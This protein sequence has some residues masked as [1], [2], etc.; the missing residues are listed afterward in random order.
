M[1]RMS[2]GEVR[3]SCARCG[4]SVGRIDGEPIELPETWT[5]PDGQS[6]CLSCSRARAGEAAIDLAPD[7][8]SI[9]DRARVRRTALIEF[10]IGRMP[11]AGDSAIASACRTSKGAVA[12][13]RG[14]LVSAA[15]EDRDPA[16]V[17]SA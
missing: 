14:G 11:E 7:T 16:L 3:W 5:R 8:I 1:S 13:V 15:A 10:E 17:P 2:I 9:E 12:T 4:V 6:F